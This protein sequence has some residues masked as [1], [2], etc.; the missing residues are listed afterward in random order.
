MTAQEIKRLL[1]LEPLSRE[2]GWYKK[3]Y[4]S[5]EFLP[6]GALPGRAGPHVAGGAILFLL[7]AHT[8]SRMHRLQT[9]EVYHF[10]LGTPVELLILRPDGT[11][12]RVVLGQ[13]IQNGQRVQAVVPRGCWQGSRVLPGAAADAY[14]L[15]G[16]TLAPDYEEADYEDGEMDALIAAYPAFEAALRV[17]AGAP[18]Y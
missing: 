14:A 15:I 4:R 8:Y 9:D 2:G 1:G 17:L 11:G 13:D 3:S 10:Y 6:D 18:Q 12:E 5:D 16:T 7:E